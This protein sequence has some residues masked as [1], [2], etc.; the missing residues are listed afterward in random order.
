MTAGAAVG[1]FGGPIGVVFGAMIGGIVGA[2]GLSVASHNLMQDI[3]K[4][5]FNLPPTIAEENA[6]RFLGVSP[7]ASIDEINRAYRQKALFA[8]PDRGGSNDAFQ[9]LQM[10][11][12][13]IRFARGLDLIE[14]GTN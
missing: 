13:I 5:I 1:A 6:Y 4:A 14:G 12:Q 9:Q 7:N 11:L 8:H 10:H 3:T 2:V